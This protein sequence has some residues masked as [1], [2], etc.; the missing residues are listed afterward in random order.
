M[1][2][3]VIPVLDAAASLVSC[4][5]ALKGA[6][7]IIVVDGGSAD[8]SAAIADRSG[9]RV[10]VAPRGRGTQLHTGGKAARGDW[11]LFLHADTRLGAGW[12]DA[13]ATHLATAQESAGYFDLRLDDGAW[14][15]RVIE[16]GVALRVRLLGLPYGD[17]GL[18]ISRRLYEELGGFRPLA[19]MEDVDLVRRIGRHRLRRLAATA[20]TSADRWRRDGWIGRSARNLACL[21]LYAGGVAPARLARFYR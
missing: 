13:V 12:R 21:A 8:S 9:A 19:L 5:A 16:R 17:Q 15:A 10:I 20:L 3:I 2:T 6:D 7:E 11:L 14:Q 1:L 18:L 4:L